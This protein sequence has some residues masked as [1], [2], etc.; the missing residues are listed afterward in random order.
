MRRLS[1]IVALS[2][3]LKWNMFISF[4]VKFYQNP[5]MQTTIIADNQTDI[6]KLI[7]VMHFALLQNILKECNTI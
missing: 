4:N 2:N 3:I 5:F 6:V 1:D 7:G